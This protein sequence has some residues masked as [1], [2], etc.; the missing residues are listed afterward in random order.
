MGFCFQGEL[1]R[2]PRPVSL[3]ESPCFPEA[4]VSWHHLQWGAA[5]RGV[6]SGGEDLGMGSARAF[7]EGAACGGGEEWKTVLL[8]WR[9]VLPTPASAPAREQT[10]GLT[11]ISPIRPSSPGSPLLTPYS[12]KPCAARSV[13]LA[14][15]AID[16]S[17]PCT[18]SPSL[19]PPSSPCL[20][21][22]PL[23]LSAP[24]SRPAA[25]FSPWMQ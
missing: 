24:P 11:A 3:S 14:A 2:T 22:A 6:W 5:R 18:L 16:P 13:A 21:S 4:L 19:C 1:F 9:S 23:V 7:G 17:P 12:L 15:V 8:L 10:D 20:L 25:P